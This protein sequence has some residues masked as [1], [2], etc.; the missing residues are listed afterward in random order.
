MVSP[1]K[2]LANLQQINA[3]YF[4]HYGKAAPPDT[5]V[6]SWLPFYHDMGLIIGIV[7]PVLAG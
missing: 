3:D 4:E 6:V 2:V 5:T 1:G 7:F